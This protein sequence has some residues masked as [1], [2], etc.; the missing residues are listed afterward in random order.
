MA[1]LETTELPLVIVVQYMMVKTHLSGL[2]AHRVHEMYPNCELRE[3]RISHFA[4]I[5]TKPP[6]RVPTSHIGSKLKLA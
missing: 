1:R 3:L 2:R 6:V 4:Y 5:S